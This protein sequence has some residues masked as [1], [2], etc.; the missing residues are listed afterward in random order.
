[1]LSVPAY[2]PLTPH[3]P[4]PTRP[5]RAAGFTDAILRTVADNME[6]CDYVE[7][8]DII[9]QN[10][11]GDSFY[12]LERGRVKIMRRA[13]AYEDAHEIRRLGKGAHFGELSLLNEEPRSATVTVVS[14]T[15]RALKLSKAAFD[16]IITKLRS[17]G[18][19]RKKEV[20]AKAIVERVPMFKT[21]SAALKKKILDT[22]EEQKFAPGTYI[23]KQG[24]N[25]TS[26]Y[27]ITSGQCKITL[28]TDNGKEK[29]V[30]QYK[31]GDFFGENALVDAATTKR[32]ANVIATEDVTCMT[33]SKAEFNYLMKGVKS[34]LLQQ[35]DKIKISDLQVRRALFTLPV[36]F[37]D[38]RT[39]I[40]S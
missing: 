35:R 3:P 11:T 15:A 40:N 22:M 6:V 7:N 14:E 2:L 31:A 34:I 19:D 21:L 12:V 9:V 25:G 16:E 20:S 29:E 1:M 38:P 8:D 5:S 13:N 23:C 28:N 30:R 10:D 36:D 27:I 4:P 37:S 18:G 32:T 17:L 26:F 33:L 39:L 24:T